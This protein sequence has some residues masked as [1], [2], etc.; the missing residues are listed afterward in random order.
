[1]PSDVSTQR[2]KYHVNL[3]RLSVSWYLDMITA[4]KLFSTVFAILHS[5]LDRDIECTVVK[6]Q[7]ISLKFLEISFYQGK[8]RTKYAHWVS[9]ELCGVFTTRI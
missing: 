3:H 9:C 2:E 1:V 4:L 5:C 7:H 8:T 6:K